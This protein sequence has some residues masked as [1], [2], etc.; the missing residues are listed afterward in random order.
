MWSIGMPS[1]STARAPFTGLAKQKAI[2]KGA[3]LIRTAVG[4]ND[5]MF[6]TGDVIESTTIQILGGAPETL[7]SLQFNGKALNFDIDES[8]TVIAYIEKPK[9]SYEIPDLASLQWKAIDSLPE[10]SSSYSDKN[11][12]NAREKSYNDRQK[13]RT[14]TS[15]LASDYGYNW[16][17]H[18]FRGHF[19]STGAEKT[20]T[21]HT[22]GGSA[23]GVSVWLDDQ[24]IGSFAGSADFEE[25]I[26]TFN[27]PESKPE[28]KRILTIVLD[29]M[30]HNQNWNVGFDDSKRPLG[31]LNYTLS[32][33]KQ[34]SIS[35]KING[36]H[37]GEDY[38]D[39]ARGPANEGG[40][41][42]E[43]HGYHLPNPPTAGW[44]DS[45]GPTEGLQKAGIA[46]YSTSFDL[47]I[48]RELD[49]PIAIQVGTSSDPLVDAA[50]RPAYRLQ[51]FVNGW[52]FGKYTNNI[53]PQRKFPV[54]VGIWNYR[55]KNWVAVSL[56]NL[57]GKEVK[58]E[59]FKL[60]TGPEIY[61]GMQPVETVISPA[62]TE[63]KGAS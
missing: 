8:G 22:R 52:Q 38:P 12:V 28:A 30:G 7:S 4:I 33:R 16:G 43:R 6:L 59:E 50:K 41:W 11:W 25:N 5:R 15:L 62:W 31:I 57:D 35:W 19:Q 20:F 13:L 10:I 17:Y 3:Y 14:P 40:L 53:G 24:F 26:N 32:G 1:N 47:N 34:D 18:L 39:R 23:Y 54:P 45:K 48:P 2:I 21:L 58:V 27:L 56:W 42:A 60:V 29:N 37:G 46:F 9:F 63:R 51:I 61:S 44:K 36:N 55:G 49:L